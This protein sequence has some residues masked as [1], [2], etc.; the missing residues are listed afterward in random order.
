MRSADVFEKRL[1]DL[2]GAA[3][4]RFTQASANLAQGIGKR[5]LRR[6]SP[7]SQPSAQR[8][9]EPPVRAAI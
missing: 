8:E 3:Q 7:C 1:D 2:V 5:R 4:S 6:R 9:T